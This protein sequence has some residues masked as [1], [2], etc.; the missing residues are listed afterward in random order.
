MDNEKI[1]IESMIFVN[2]YHVQIGYKLS[3][4]TSEKIYN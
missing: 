2:V 4:N 1:E 3:T